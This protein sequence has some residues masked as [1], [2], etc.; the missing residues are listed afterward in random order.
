MAFRGDMPV[1]AA[2]EALVL[3][4]SLGIRS[5]LPDGLYE[6]SWDLARQLGWAKTHDAE[7]VALALMV[8]VPLLTIDG[9]LR[10]GAG[11]L[12]DMPLLADL[13]PAT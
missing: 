9:R 7:Y 12:V 4:P 1:D 10:R 2:R 6:R 13:E 8:G 3:L 5:L 11:H